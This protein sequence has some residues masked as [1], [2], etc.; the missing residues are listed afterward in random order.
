[1]DRK[2]GPQKGTK[3]TKKNKSKYEKLCSLTPALVLFCAFCAFLRLLIG[4]EAITDPGFGEDVAWA[5]RVGLDL[6]AQV[7]DEHAQVFVLLDVVAA[8]EGRQQGAM[9]Q[10]FSGV[11][12]EVDE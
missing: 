11:L 6:L 4:I 3:G 5:R 2:K 8:P 10:N 1:M 12:Y 9:S 7:T